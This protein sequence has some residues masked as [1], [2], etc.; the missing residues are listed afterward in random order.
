[1]HMQVEKRNGELVPHDLSKVQ[2]VIAWACH[3]GNGDGLAP[4]KGVSPSAI[5]LAAKLNYRDG[6]KTSEIHQFLIDGTESLIGEENPNYDLVAGRL[7]NFALRKEVYGTFRI[8]HIYDLVKKGVRGGWYHPEVIGLY[9]EDEWNEIEAFVDHAR[10]YS[11]KY[12]GVMKMRNSYLVQSKNTGEI[13]ET[14]Q[15][16]MV[17]IGA[18][19][20]ATYPVETRLSYVKR[21]YDAVSTFKISLPTPVMAGVRT[22]SKQYSSCVLVDVD[23]SLDSIG[24]A[25]TVLM[26]YGA[27]RAGLG[28]NV[29]RIRA[30]GQPVKKGLFRAGGPI[31]FYDFLRKAVKSCTQSGIRP[32]SGT[33]NYPFWHLDFYSLIVLKNNKG[34]DENRIRNMDYCVHFNRLIFERLHA[35]SDLTLFSPEEVPALYELFYGKDYGAFKAE[36]ERCEADPALTKRKTP[37]LKLATTFLTERLETGRIYAMFA[38]NVNEHTTL[39]DPIYMTNLCVEILQATKPLQADGSGRTALC[40]LAANNWGE[41]HTDEEMAEA[42]EMNVRALDA[43]LD[44]QEYQDPS[45]YAHTME[46]R[47]LGVGIINFAYWLH[48]SG[49]RWGE[50]AA[51]AAVAAKA[52]SQYYYLLDASVRLAEERGSIRRELTIHADGKFVWELGARPAEAVR[53][54]EPLRARMVKFGVRNA[55]VSA[56]MP[57]EA[58]SQVSGATNGVEPPK[59]LVVTKGSKD[60]KY[61][62]VVPGYAKL[63]HLYQ[64]QWSIPVPDYLQTLAPAQQFNDQGMSTNTSYDP[65]RFPN[66]MLPMTA[67][68][69]DFYMAW[70]LGFPTLYYNNQNKVEEEGSKPDDDC[71]GGACKI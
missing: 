64:T 36:Y 29:G 63:N 27:N 48:S 47:P 14:P 5:E 30:Q 39:K 7:A 28:I 62:F 67:L 34:T 40:T 46:Y 16:A 61:P 53:D 58:S 59:D 25:G 71:A 65:F 26:K 18:C 49:L 45:A 66:S 44:F 56:N 12:L 41:I 2:K 35:N 52:E 24:L 38:D 57:S 9:S 8:P 68:M 42:C 51:S 11:L 31:P 17:L 22:T 37:A 4:I 19:L 69:A 1:M 6:M 32:A 70:R 21:F 54:W 55:T 60:G 33:F 20:F 3:G 43:L 50:K 23:D 10:D 15:V 13:Y